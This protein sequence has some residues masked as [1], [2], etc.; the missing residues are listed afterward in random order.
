MMFLCCAVAARGLVRDRAREGGDRAAEE[1][2]PGERRPR[3][4]SRARV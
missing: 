2:H 4:R 1:H 3:S